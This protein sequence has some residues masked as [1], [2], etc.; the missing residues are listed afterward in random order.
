VV[1]DAF[2]VLKLTLRPD[3]YDWEFLPIAGESFTERGTSTCH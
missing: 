1:S 2:G 3:G